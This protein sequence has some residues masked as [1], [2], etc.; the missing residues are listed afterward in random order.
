LSCYTNNMQASGAAVDG[1][2]YEVRFIA[3]GYQNINAVKAAGYTK[4]RISYEV[5]AYT[6][7][8]DPGVQPFV[9]FNKTW[10]GKWHDL[11]GNS[12]TAEIDF[13][14][15]WNDGSNQV[16][17]GVQFS[18]I[19]GSISYKITAAE[20][21]KG[22]GS[23][24][25]GGS[26]SGGGSQTG[27]TIGDVNGE[28]EL[29]FAKLL[30]ES[31]Y[32]YDANMCGCDVDEKSHFSWR[33]DCHTDDAKVTYNGKTVDVSGGYHDAGDHVKFGL[34][35]AVSASM[36]G[37]SY[38]EYKD[39]YDE[40]GLTAHYKCIMDRFADY[41]ER[42]TV[43]TNGKVETFCYQVGEGNDD[44][45]WK[46]KPEDQ[47]GS[48]A[49]YFTSS[50]D[51]CT[52]IVCET[53]A[54]LAI[55]SMNFNDEKSLEYAKALFEYADGMGNKANSK[56][57]DGYFYDSSSYKDD[58]AFA[59]AMLYKATGE[60]KYKTAYNSCSSDLYCGWPISWD[61]VKALGA[62]YAPDGG[63]ANNSVAEYVSG[64]AA[65]AK[66]SEGFVLLN[67]WG[68]ARYN[69]ALQ[70]M[71][72][73]ADKIQNQDRFYGWAK[74]QM[75]YLLG[76]NAGKHC[77]VTGYNDMSVK[78][79]HHRA[80]YDSYSFPNCTGAAKHLMIGAL[81]GGPMSTSTA[82][83][84]NAGDYTQNEVALDYNA[85]L[86]C[87]AASLYHCEKQKGTDEEKAL[88]KT[89]EMSDIQGIELR[90]SQD[91]L[92]GDVNCDGNVDGKDE[93]L[94]LK[95][96]SGL[97]PLSDTTNADM[98]GDGNIDILDIILILG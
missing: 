34:P 92:K 30:Q 40:L 60:A 5:S 56:G 97:K 52:D 72:L 80:V 29:N 12:G 55:Y 20:L 42:C 14:N 3:P 7:N 84:D 16:Y 70:F 21:V 35:A 98:N 37:I 46:T 86:V 23:S 58:Y 96:I 4:L 77:F 18:N 71:G 50:S 38:M 65:S 54:A 32:F 87:A 85:C 49:V 13:D 48:R 69:A 94:I 62:L 28:V 64:Q 11:K 67:Q 66:N 43:M 41:F 93:K 91:T 6:A 81:V 9:T 10:A 25:S 89:I 76:N 53:A 24:S 73:L 45:N 82:Y 57:R 79:P 47:T 27:D 26:S 51:P 83:T 90:T 68:S 74:G 95:H 78:N 19:T 33:N 1:T 22:N 44:H 39:D 88:Q 17:F 2:T 75:S 63:T 59:S 31:L 8:G 15:A 61:D 36:L